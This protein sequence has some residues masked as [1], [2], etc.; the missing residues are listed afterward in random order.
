[1]TIGYISIGS[2][3]ERNKHIAAGVQALQHLFGELVVS[4]V[5]EADAVGFPGA[6]FYNLV[7][8]FN[9]ELDVH[10]IAQLL[11]K[12]EFAHGR[13]ADSQKFSARTLDLDLLLYGD[14][15]INDDSLQL[16]RPDIERYAFV[17]EPLAEIAPDLQHPLLQQSYAQ[18]WAAMAKTKPL[19]WRV[20]VALEVPPE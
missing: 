17:L 14:T 6:P 8:G 7:V 9:S 19:Q 20:D 18:L 13:P 15:V 4:S 10:T 16:P 2:N 1:M 12:L 5:Y 11:R 3:I